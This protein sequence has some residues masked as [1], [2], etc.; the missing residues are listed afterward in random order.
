MTY[1]QL[2]DLIQHV[3]YKRHTSISLQPLP[4]ADP[5]V[6][7]IR[8]AQH[9]PNVKARTDQTT[10]IGLV[11]KLTRNDLDKLTTLSFMLKLREWWREFECHEV[12]EWL[13]L[14]GRTVV[15]PHPKPKGWRAILQQ[16]RATA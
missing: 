14:D 13:Q 5:Y 16:W 3:T 10:T 4:K 7:R 9:L 6:A 15:D 2:F 8:L 11:R 12:D 1:E